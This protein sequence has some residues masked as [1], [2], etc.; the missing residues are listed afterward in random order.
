[1][2]TIALINPPFASVYR[3]SIALTQ[4]SHV[5]AAESGVPARICYLNLTIARLV[6]VG[7]YED[8]ADQHYMQ[9]FGDWVFRALAY[10]DAEDN[11]AEYIGR[12]YAGSASPHRAQAERMTALRP[13]MYA[14][15][16]S[17]VDEQDLASFDI[18][19]LTSMFSQN[20]ASFAIAR[21][22]KERNPGATVI[23]GG[24]NCE[25]PMGSA[26][27]DNVKWIDY[28]FSG[29]SIASFREFLRRGR[30]G[31]PHDTASRD[32]AP[33]GPTF[34]IPGI[35]GQADQPARPG[36]PLL[37]D[38]GSPHRVGARNDIDEPV[39]LDYDGYLDQ[40]DGHFP[41][42]ASRPSL[43]FETSRGCWWGERSQCTF[44]GLNGTGMSY[45]AMSPER[46]AAHIAALFRYAGRAKVLAG[47]DNILPRSFISQV[48][49][50]LRTP[51]GMSLF[52]EVKV[53]LTDRDLDTLRAA[54]VRDIQP[55]IESLST[56]TLRLMRKGTSAFQNI[57]FLR[58]ARSAGIRP[59]WLILVGFPGE[60]AEVYQKYLR[61]LPLLT[62]L[63]P[64]A[65]AI[66]VRFDRYSAYFEDPGKYGL[67]LRPMRFYGLTYPMSQEALTD[68][69]YYFYDN[70]PDPAYQRTCE[71]YLAT[72]R[73]LVG[74]WQDRWRAGPRPQLRVMP[75]S[76]GLDGA[77]ILDSRAGQ[78]VFRSVS[79][80]GLA[81][82][83][84]LRRPL[85][86]D[87]AAERATLDPEQARDEITRLRADGL[88]FEE[89]GMYL[90]LLTGPHGLRR[91]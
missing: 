32:N 59:T 70:T 86:A 29:P 21:L 15:V 5:A 28:V 9:G 10:P 78:P 66:P 30:G 61:D 88:L 36:L 75:D 55:G 46:A 71:Q 65:N 39:A 85:T 33:P 24:A 6:G 7:L 37:A 57:M 84:A 87:G 1:V 64:P 62:H 8:I 4:L 76:L 17:Y 68:L 91:P 38:P 90:S 35:F 34:S 13:D 26:I 63:H 20:M 81:V 50:H 49:P 31:A 23:M 44:C 72:L 51:P 16:T 67:D 14:A 47:V 89:R 82:L 19:G 12:M 80:A 43:L 73:E 56:P 53:G 2:T 40:F 83:H 58:G 11:A 79:A 60:R 45:E 3:P 69:A 54:G 77:V 52:F 42:S 74:Q 48:L 41:D 18:V 25:A 27:R 22:I